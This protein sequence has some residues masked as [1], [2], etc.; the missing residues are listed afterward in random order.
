MGSPS[1]SPRSGGFHI[2]EHHDDLAGYA[3]AVLE[4]IEEPDFIAEGWEGELVAVR[5]VDRR[6]LAVVYREVTRADG[7]VITAFFIR[8]VHKWVQRKRR[9]P[10]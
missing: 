10:K 5:R 4:A 2:T 6:H 7:F 9:W 3:P 8:K 1:A